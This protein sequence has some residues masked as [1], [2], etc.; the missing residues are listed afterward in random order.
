VTHTVLLG[1]KINVVQDELRR[2]LRVLGLFD[3]IGA[4]N[5]ISGVGN[6]NFKDKVHKINNSLES[7]KSGLLLRPLPLVTNRNRRKCNYITQ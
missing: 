6:R 5:F 2:F 1:V 7:D 3:K 4:Q